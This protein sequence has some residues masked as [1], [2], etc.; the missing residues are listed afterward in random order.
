MR[1]LIEGSRPPSILCGLTL[2]LC[3]SALAAC[4]SAPET[5]PPRAASKDPDAAFNEVFAKM[6]VQ[7]LMK[8]RVKPEGV[9]VDDEQV[10]AFESPYKVSDKDQQRKYVPFLIKPLYDAACELNPSIEEGKGEVFKCKPRESVMMLD[11]DAPH[12]LMVALNA[13]LEAAQARNHRLVIRGRDGG[14]DIF[15]VQGPMVYGPV[16]DDTTLGAYFDAQKV[17]VYFESKLFQEH[18]CS[19]NGADTCDPF[20]ARSGYDLDALYQALSAIKQ[21]HPTEERIYFSAPDDYPVSLLATFARIV[22]FRTTP[23]NELAEQAMSVAEQIKAT[24]LYDDSCR[25][26][27][28]V[29]GATPL[30]LFPTIKLVSIL[31]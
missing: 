28:Q 3:L 10:L 16:E 2:V 30:C 24:S 20:A 5:T 9:F 7:G 27:A 22:R 21:E 14:F 8:V 31:H 23:S 11:S 4:K 1:T 17:S 13:T 29:L 19:L 12:G 18:K 15:K 25:S 6:P 26:S